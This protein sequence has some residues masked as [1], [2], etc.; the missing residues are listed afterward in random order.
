MTKVINKIEEKIQSDDTFLKKLKKSPKKVFEEITNIKLPDTMKVKLET[1]SNPMEIIIALPPSPE[2]I[3][4]FDKSYNKLIKLYESMYF[5][6]E[7][8]KSHKKLK[9]AEFQQWIVTE[10]W[11]N[12]KFMERL[13]SAPKD[14]V[15]SMLTKKLDPKVEIKIVKNN[16]NTLHLPIRLQSE[17]GQISEVELKRV[18][19]GLGHAPPPAGLRIPSRWTQNED[20]T[21]SRV[22]DT[23][24][25]RTRTRGRG[26]RRR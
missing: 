20:Q 17:S 5:N 15:Q 8:E 2:M 24:A 12:K 22:S 16:L 18:A 10:A 9:D 13:N 6:A 1:I 25:G 11:E 14:A 7:N 21:G 19:G 26:G 23:M 3:K 4:Q